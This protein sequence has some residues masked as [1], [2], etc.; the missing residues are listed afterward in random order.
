M[1]DLVVRG[2]TI[3]TIDGVFDGDVAIRRGRIVA[4]A[5]PGIL[6]QAREMIDASGLL[7]FPGLVDP[8]VHLGHRIFLDDG[9]VSAADDFAT[10]SGTA[11]AGGTT[12]VIDF[13]IQR[14]LDP[15]AT[16]AARRAEAEGRVVIDY[17][18]HPALTRTTPE[19]LDAIS[20]LI[21]AGLP[22]FKLY[23]IYR[24]QG[25]MADD[26]MLFNTLRETATRG[27]LVGVHAENAPIA[28]FNTEQAVRQA[29]TTAMDFAHTKPSD[30]EAEAIN[31]ALFFAERS[32]GTLYIFH[33]STRDGLQLVGA[34]RAR[35]VKVFAET[36]TH[37]LTLTEGVYSEPDGHRF[38]CSPPLRP[39]SDV[40]ALWE[41][42]A[43]GVLSV[44]SSDHCGFD[45]AAKDRGRADFTR[46]PNGLP[47]IGARFPVM[48][49]HAVLTGILTLPQLV[50]VLSTNPA[51][52][53]GL[54]PRKGAIQPGSDAD[55]VLIDPGRRLKI[56]AAAFDSPIDWSPYAG[57]ELSGWPVMTIAG[58]KAVAR[59]GHCLV[60]PGR[61]RGR[62]LTRQLFPRQPDVPR[63]RASAGDERMEGTDP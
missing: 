13:A 20:T 23:M 8:H 43:T 6:P 28:E 44:V 55:L 32:H 60:A 49:T 52:V 41:G 17:S 45:M 5:G 61:G 7:V 46:V 36:C 40:E 58:G 4:V 3:V 24:K 9:W 19:T 56:S 42:L 33:L 39:A 12:A 15:I 48:Y 2:G 35:G 57:M 59:N 38:I 31:R 29:K 37:Y 22:S 50:A 51:R 10:G 14:D 11:A 30:V 26:A 54:Y 34:A 1:L 21:T 16:V 47:G 27:G 25:R 18:V 62:F 63:S 53:F